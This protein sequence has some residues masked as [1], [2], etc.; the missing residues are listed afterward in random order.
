[1]R[2]DVSGAYNRL[3]M[4]MLYLP[5][6]ARLLEAAEL[7]RL[8]RQWIQSPPL[9][10]VCMKASSQKGRGNGWDFSGGMVDVSQSIQDVELSSKRVR[11]ERLMVRV[12]EGI[13]IFYDDVGDW[14]QREC[15]EDAAPS[16]SPTAPRP[17]E[18]LAFTRSVKGYHEANDNAPTHERWRDMP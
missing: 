5:L 11:V 18:G 1:M 8:S 15:P 7:F 3:Q 6:R 2:T 12:Q 10:I 17:L 16:C 14:A 13:F 9:L 4:R